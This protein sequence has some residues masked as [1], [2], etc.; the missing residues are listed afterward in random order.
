MKNVY[1]IITLL[2]CFTTVAQN[3]A[4]RGIIKDAI[5]KEPIIAASVGVQHS[6]LGTISNEEGDFQMTVPQTATIGITYLGYKTMV[7]PV[8]EFKEET[9]TIL[10]EQSEET[11]EE[12]IVTKVPLEQVMQDVIDASK[13]RF[14]KPI[15]LHTYYREFVKV[16]NKYKKFSDA[17]LDYHASGGSKKTK[18]DLIVKQNR[19]FSLTTTDEEEDEQLS[20]TLNVQRGIFNSYSFEF[21]ERNILK[22][23]NLENYELSLK[24]RK[25]AEGHQLY[26]IIIEPKKDIEK[27]LF[28]GTVIYDPETKLIYEFDLH[29][30]AS[31]KSFARTISFLGMHASMLDMK[32]KAVYKMTN[33]YVLSHNNRFVKYKTWT[34]KYN[35]LVESRSDLIVTDFEKDDLTYNKKEVYKKKYLYDKPTSCNGKFWQKNNAIVLTDEEERVISSLEKAVYGVPK[36]E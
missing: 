6:G 12:V 32:V 2:F 13:A 3:I 34:K 35:E 30:A 21:L 26:A 29:Y 4:I 24:S 19:S 22:E 25:N 28:E 15:V 10:L 9:K 23:K 31:H 8:T 18:T 7:I 1:A 20:P 5:T 33:N 17:L 36:S 14:N 16:D 11:I 27:P